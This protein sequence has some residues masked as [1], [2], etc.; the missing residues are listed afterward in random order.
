MKAEVR[1]SKHGPNGKPLAEIAV[2]QNINAQE[3]SAV[4]HSVATNQTV[5][6]LGGLAACAGCKSG[7]DFSVVD[8]FPEAVFVEVQG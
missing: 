4:M 8:T 7:L 3:L 1:V 2:P 6:R 5:L